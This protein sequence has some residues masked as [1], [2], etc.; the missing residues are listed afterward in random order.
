MACNMLYLLKDLPKTIFLNAAG[1]A[2]APLRLGSH[3]MI[4]PAP[5]LSPFAGKSLFQTELSRQPEEGC[6]PRT[7]RTMGGHVQG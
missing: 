4:V 2:F 6:R 3:P 1:F 7:F 5:G